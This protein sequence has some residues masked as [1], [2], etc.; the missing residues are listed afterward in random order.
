MKVLEKRAKTFTPDWRMNREDPDPGTVLASVFAHQVEETLDRLNGSLDNYHRAF[1][2]LMNPVPQMGKP[3][4]VPLA[5]T[6]STGY[7]EILS[8][9]MGFQVEGTAEGGDRLVYETEEALHVY[10]SVLEETYF[11]HGRS[12]QIHRGVM[13]EQQLGVDPNNLQENALYIHTGRVFHIY[14]PSQLNVVIKLSNTHANEYLN[15][16]VD[17]DNCRWR[18]FSNEEWVDFDRVWLEGSVIVLEK[19]QEGDIGD[20]NGGPELCLEILKAL[21][22]FSH[23]QIMDITLTSELL[24][25]NNVLQGYR[26]N[27]KNHTV[28]EATIHPFGERLSRLTTFDLIAN[29][30][31]SKSGSIISVSMDFDVEDIRGDSIQNPIDWKMIMRKAEL[32]KLQP[33]EVSIYS[34]DWQYYSPQGWQPLMLLNGNPRGFYKH[35]AGTPVTI[36][37][38]CPKD[39][40]AFEEETKSSY[41]IRAE[42]QRVENEH[43][44]DGIYKV[45]VVKNIQMRYEYPS[46]QKIEGLYSMNALEEKNLLKELK[47]NKIYSRPFEVLYDDQ[48][49]IYLPFNEKLESGVLQLLWTLGFSNY[50]E[51]D[52]SIRVDYADNNGEVLEWLPLKF[53]DGTMSLSGTGILKLFLTNPIQTETVFGRRASWIRLRL[54]E[55]EWRNYTGVYVNGVYANQQIHIYNE[56]L[57]T[58]Q[59]KQGHLIEYEGVLDL[60]VWV[61]E[62][63]NYNDREIQ[64]MI[65]KGLACDYQ[66]DGFD[67]FTQCWI[68]WDRVDTLLGET[69]TARVYTF[70]PLTE[71]LD[72]GDGRMG[73]KPP[74][75]RS[76]LIRLTLRLSE[77]RDG[78]IKSFQIDG[79]VSSKAFM[80]SVLNPAA[81]KGGTGGE[82]VNRVIERQ[83][84]QMRSRNALIDARDYEAFLMANFRNLHEVKCLTNTSDGQESRHGHLMLVLASQDPSKERVSDVLKKE[85]T[86]MISKRLPAGIRMNAVHLKDA[87]LMEIGASITIEVQNEKERHLVEH[88][89]IK[90]LEHFLH[91]Q[92]GCWG[93]GWH[94]GQSPNQSVFY[95]LMQAVEGVRNVSKVE[96]E[97]NYI[98]QQGKRE[99][100]QDQITSF[101][102]YLIIS[103]KHQIV[104][105]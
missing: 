48:W 11:V 83:H 60:E 4:K 58:S 15:A 20:F 64:E 89:C 26:T 65:N 45:P 10:P 39:I 53:S 79:M 72:F 66:K 86:T 52:E 2:N 49:A 17:E 78:N 59:D 24:D 8:L 12:N 6:S 91:H 61:D 19:H 43:R 46:Y 75:G 94:I 82:T 22:Y 84:H 67:H 23:M 51:S 36:E 93:E 90:M 21:P 77:G 101:N 63:D 71:T 42:V 3:A 81:G 13:D 7:K 96:L 69:P 68:R 103:G 105:E 35:E 5:F 28:V 70:D 33:Q 27:E 37:F 74:Y 88:R 38:L 1:L 56:L 98:D 29:D 95:K 41:M 73:K 80:N 18:Y 34:V 44:T 104:I 100:R 62:L 87:A 32:A 102:D 92:K 30:V 16:L 31:L 55:V 25:W 97:F 85:M 99:L 47:D 57:D 50:S 54:S 40:Q 14:A 9:P 76:G